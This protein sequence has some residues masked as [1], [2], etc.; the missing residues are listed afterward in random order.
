MKW[1]DWIESRPHL[2]SKWHNY[3][4]YLISTIFTKLSNGD[5]QPSPPRHRIGRIA[6]LL[7]TKF[8]TRNCR[9]PTWHMHSNRRR[10]H[11][12]VSWVGVFKLELGFVG[13]WG[14]SKSNR[15]LFEWQPADPIISVIGHGCSNIDNIDNI[16][17][18]IN[19]LY[20]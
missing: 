7:I 15:L 20:I 12:W 1:I 13:K 14:T 3:S 9:D 16:Y 5:Q 6:W 19:I 4:I 18:Y 17:I 8:E 2:G 11:S 10:V